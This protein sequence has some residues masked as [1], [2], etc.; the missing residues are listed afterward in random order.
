MRIGLL[1]FHNADNY[2]AVLQCY[3]LQQY[4]TLLGHNV[5]IINYVPAQI[6]KNYAIWN[7][8]W[9]FKKIFFPHK[10]YK[11]I[12]DSQRRWKKR[13]IFDSFRQSY[14][15]ITKEYTFQTIPLEFDAYIIGSDQVLSIGITHGLDPVYSGN[16]AKRPEAKIIGYAIGSNQKSIECIDQ[17][18][19]WDVLLNRFDAF[20]L[21]EPSLAS[22]V[23]RMSKVGIDICVDPTLLL[24]KTDWNAL[25]L[26][27][28]RFQNHIVVYQVR[29]VKGQKHKLL[30]KAKHLAENNKNSGIIDLSSGIYSIQEWLSFVK[31]AK[32][33]ITTSFHATAF[34]MIFGTPIYAFKL[35]D[36]HDDRYV[37]LLKSLGAEKSI[38]DI[39]DS[40][41]IFPVNSL[42]FKSSNIGKLRQ[43]SYNYL[44]TSIIG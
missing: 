13:K 18:I 34:S 43:S 30:E 16:F 6:K 23:N 3:A 17:T 35:H 29:Y 39:N 10:L 14:L 44:R 1:T 38:C 21:R 24:D 8:K 25:C 5:E 37:D 15:N 27:D 12:L 4:L 11:F 33:V 36:G 22:V 19:G 9:A 20:S 26:N 41:S 42:E 7:W 32:C 2:G 28:K 40:P 31:Y